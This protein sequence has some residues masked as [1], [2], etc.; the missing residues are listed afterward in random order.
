LKGL[1]KGYSNL[2]KLYL[3]IKKTNEART[4][5]YMAHQ[6]AIK[7]GYQSGQS[8]TAIAIANYYLQQKVSDSSVFFFKQSLNLLQTSSDDDMLSDVYKGLYSAYKLKGDSNQALF[9]HEKL[10]ES[11]TNRLNVENK[12][13]LSSLL[14]DFDYERKEK[15]NR[16]L[17]QENEVKNLTI[18]RNR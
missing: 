5:L 15:D 16:I 10:L 7:S 18:K 3:A 13:Q 8:E 2:G 6:L 1:I 12:R 14:L 17:K 9:Y 11:V 4:Y